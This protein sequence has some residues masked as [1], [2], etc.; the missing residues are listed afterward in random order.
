MRLLLA[1]LLAVTPIISHA[2]NI[3]RAQA[4]IKAASAGSHPNAEGRYVC[5]VPDYGGFAIL[6]GRCDSGVWAGTDKDLNPLMGICKAG[7]LQA[8]D[9]DLND[10]SG[11]CLPN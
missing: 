7:H 4:A 9:I 3:I 11:P 10:V 1:V 6:S 8:V 2:E 5:N